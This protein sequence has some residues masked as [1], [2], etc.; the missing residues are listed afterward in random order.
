L[1][2]AVG[3]EARQSPPRTWARLAS[4]VGGWQV[5]A[6]VIDMNNLSGQPSEAQISTAVAGHGAKAIPSR[7]A[8]VARGMGKGVVLA[9][10]GLIALLSV[11]RPRSAGRGHQWGRPIRRPW[12]LQEPHS[13]PV[14]R[15][16]T[17]LL[18]RACARMTMDRRGDRWTTA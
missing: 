15:L 2:H 11:S 16:F 13:S 1:P 6:W 14:S 9:V 8:T 18:A 5:F 7:A 4:L 3:E 12:M 17:C 10:T